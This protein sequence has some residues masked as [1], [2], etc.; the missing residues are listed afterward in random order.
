MAQEQNIQVEA[1]NTTL[2]GV[3]SNNALISHTKEEFVLDFMLVHPPK[4]LLVSR[5][6][7]SPAHF[8]RM[9]KA[10]Q[11]NLAKYESQFGAIP[12]ATGVE[13]HEVGFKA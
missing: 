1:D 13:P 9:V 11:E 7:T 3:Y 10:M 8:K 2:K 12:D 6:M 5:T 4:G